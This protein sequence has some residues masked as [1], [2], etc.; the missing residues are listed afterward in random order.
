MVNR[1]FI[2]QFDSCHYFFTVV[3]CAYCLGLEVALA[4][5]S[6][7][8]CV[9]DEVT[10]ADVCLVPQVYNAQRYMLNQMLWP[11]LVWCSSDPDSCF[12]L[13]FSTKNWWTKG[14]LHRA[15]QRGVNECW[16]CY[17]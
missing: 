3:W 15:I 6:G 4:K 9:G 10:M 11:N 8:Y 7:K 16:C 13:K 12:E 1:L 17:V 2:Q 5:T 14:Q